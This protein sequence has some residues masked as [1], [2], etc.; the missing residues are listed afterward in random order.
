MKRRAGKMR[1][2][3]KQRSRKAATKIGMAWYRSEQWNRLRQISEDVDILE[4][5]YEEWESLASRKIAELEAAGIKIEKVEVDVNELMSYCEE[6]GL[7]VNA[8]SR[9]RFVTD[10][11]RKRDE[12]AEEGS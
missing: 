9:S 11:L 3:K 6:Y 2:Y 4:T 1:R 10:K 8:E 7:A 5:N 12:R